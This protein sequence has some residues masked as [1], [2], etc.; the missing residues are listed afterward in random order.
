MQE[1]ELGDGQ[2]QIAVSFAANSG[3]LW[4]K[5]ITDRESVLAF[6]ELLDDADLP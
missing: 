6:V 3:A 4:A 1:E 5:D 2:I